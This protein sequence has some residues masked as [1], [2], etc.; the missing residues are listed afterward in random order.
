MGE[1]LVLTCLKSEAGRP[2]SKADRA[3]SV[4]STGSAT[5]DRFEAPLTF[6]EC[7]NNLGFKLI[8]EKLSLNCIK[9]EN[10]KEKMKNPKSIC[11]S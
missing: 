3:R 8:E 2:E 1:C 9:P 6:P 7:V 10:Q 4:A 11:T 5:G